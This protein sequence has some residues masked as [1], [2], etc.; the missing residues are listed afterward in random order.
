LKL[1]YICYFGIKNKTE[2]E[3]ETDKYVRNGSGSVGERNRRRRHCFMLEIERKGLKYLQFWPP[4]F[5]NVI[6]MNKNV[7]EWRK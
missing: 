6:R 1:V 5:G 2:L 3:K 7:L 4:R